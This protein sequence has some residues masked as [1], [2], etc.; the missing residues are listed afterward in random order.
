MNSFHL[1]QF[2]IN[3]ILDRDGWRICDFISS[4][5]DYLKRYF[6]NTVAANLTPDL[7]NIFVQEKVSEFVSGH[8]Y[9]F[10]LKEPEHRKIIGLIYVQ[11]VDRIKKKAEIAYCIGYSYKNKGFTSLAVK[12]ISE[13]A[14]A[15]PHLDTLR[16]IVHHS[17]I[18]SLKVAQ[19]CGYIWKKTLAKEHTPPNEEPLDMELYILKNER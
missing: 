4:N 14:I 18:A 15:Q 17:N 19:N 10:T 16:I 3:P 12:T 6:P 1:A 7:S 5:E 11:E 9:L 8:E 2:E 13:W